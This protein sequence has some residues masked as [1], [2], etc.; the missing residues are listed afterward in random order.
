MNRMGCFVP[1][2]KQENSFEI[3]NGILFIKFYGI[4]PIL[5]EIGIKKLKGII[6]KSIIE[7]FWLVLPCIT[8]FGHL[9]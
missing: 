1:N 6:L 4:I 5:K 7:I 9:Y 3:Y 8:F 2:F